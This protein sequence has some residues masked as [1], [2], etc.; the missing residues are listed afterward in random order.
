MYNKGRINV[1][2]YDNGMSKEGSHC[3]CL[4]V[5]LIDSAF[6]IRKIPYP[7]GFIE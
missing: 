1:N 5:I 2:F 6:K 7:Q 4:L 3:I